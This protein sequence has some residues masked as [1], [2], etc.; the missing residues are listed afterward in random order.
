MGERVRGGEKRVTV[1]SHNTLWTE[2]GGETWS[3]DTMEGDGDGSR[4]GVMSQN[5]VAR[6]DPFRRGKRSE[7][8]RREISR[9]REMLEMSSSSYQTRRLKSL[10]RSRSCHRGGFSGSHK[11]R[12]FRRPSPT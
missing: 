7:T 3:C 4:K 6:V 2:R 8:K 11:K 10:R 5:Q 9:W 1:R 12:E